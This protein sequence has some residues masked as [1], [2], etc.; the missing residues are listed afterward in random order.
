MLSAEDG[1]RLVRAAMI[2]YME[3]TLNIMW[4]DNRQKEV[5]EK[6]DTGRHV[7]LK[8]ENEKDDIKYIVMEDKDE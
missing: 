2:I 6:M 4:K 8:Q 5:Q 3:A 7:V 1:T